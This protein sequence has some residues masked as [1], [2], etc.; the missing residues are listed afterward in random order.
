MKNARNILEKRKL[1]KKR[2]ISF[3]KKKITRK[4]KNIKEIKDKIKAKVKSNNV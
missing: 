3:T 1:N 4:Q 2:L